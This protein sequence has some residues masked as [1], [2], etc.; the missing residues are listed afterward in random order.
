M[1][2]IKLHMDTFILFE[3][4]SYSQETIIMPILF[5]NKA[6]NNKNGYSLTILLWQ[7][8]KVAGPRSSQT[9]L[10]VEPIQQYLSM[11]VRVQ[12]KKRI[13]VQLLTW[14]MNNLVSL[15]IKL[16]SQTIK[17]HSCYNS[18]SQWIMSQQNKN[19]HEIFLQKVKATTSYSDS[20][21]IEVAKFLWANLT[22]KAL[23]M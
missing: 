10:M 16:S 19:T 6:M 23:L 18:K 9:A 12:V 15:L 3:A 5:K 21:M 4:W 20:K 11:N 13:V 1:I 22:Q 8:P 14:Q 7:S 2:L 17:I